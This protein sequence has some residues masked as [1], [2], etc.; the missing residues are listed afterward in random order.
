MRLQVNNRG[1]IITSGERQ[2]NGNKLVTRFQKTFKIP[3]NSVS[4]KITGKFQGEVLYVT[5]PK[6][7]SI[8]KN[9][10]ENQ[11]IVITA[12]LAFSLGALACHKLSK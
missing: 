7:K 11:G 12:V 9:L 10:K 6:R 5:V 4:E 1:E 2:T 3:G 8:T